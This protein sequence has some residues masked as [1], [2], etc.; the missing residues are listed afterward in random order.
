[1]GT[2]IISEFLS[3]SDLSTLGTMPVNSSILYKKCKSVLQ[4]LNGSKKFK[5]VKALIESQ[6]LLS[7][8]ESA[9]AMI[10]RRKLK[11]HD[12]RYIKPISPSAAVRV[13]SHLKQ[14]MRKRVQSR[15]SGLNGSKRSTVARCVSL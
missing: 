3:S 13:P 2:L 11:K 10:T 7:K 14:R 4:T 8:D 5:K 6:L 15:E 9:R 1:M 12:K